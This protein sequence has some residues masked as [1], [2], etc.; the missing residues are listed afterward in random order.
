MLDKQKGFT[1]VELMVAMAIGSIIILGAGQLFLTTFQTFRKV[2]E[3]SRKQEAQI[4]IPQ[5]IIEE[6]RQADYI[7]LGNDGVDIFLSLLADDYSIQVSGYSVG[8]DSDVTASGNY[9]FK[10]KNKKYDN[11]SDSS[12]YISNFISLWFDGVSENDSKDICLNISKDEFDSNY[13]FEVYDQDK[14]S[15][16]FLIYL[17]MLENVE[18]SPD[19]VC[20]KRLQSILTNLV[21]SGH[22]PMAGGLVDEKSIDISDKGDGEYHLGINFIGT[23]HDQEPFNL[24]FKVQN[25]RKFVQRV[26]AGNES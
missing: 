11:E 19:G 20:A 12:S 2:D 3:V 5:R 24:E 21:G 4:F 8:E 10:N 6:V 26:N 9:F 16:N 7:Y 15:K 25:R 22:Q 14:I 23:E 1:L 18:S 13:R 17:N